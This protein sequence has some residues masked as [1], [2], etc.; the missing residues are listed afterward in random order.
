MLNSLRKTFAMTAS[1]QIKRNV[2]MT[3]ARTGD[4][5]EKVNLI[6]LKKKLIFKARSC[7]KKTHQLCWTKVEK[8]R[9]K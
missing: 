7:S 9:S 4:L 8:S 3:S 6:S 5:G 2:Y 1:T